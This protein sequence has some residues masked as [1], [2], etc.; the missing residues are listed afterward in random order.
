M[1]EIKNNNTIIR[2]CFD[3]NSLKNHLKFYNSLVFVRAKNF[4]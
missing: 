2:L 4:S 1:R 3:W